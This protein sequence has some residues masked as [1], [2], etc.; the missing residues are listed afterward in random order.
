MLTHSNNKHFGTLTRFATLM[1]AIHMKYKIRLLSY[2]LRNFNKT[3]DTDM[4][5]VFTLMDESH[6]TV[7]LRL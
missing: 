2:I 4:T 6:Q 5:E 1:Y 3:K 7:I